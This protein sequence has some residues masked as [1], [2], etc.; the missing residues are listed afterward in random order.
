MTIL[1]VGAIEE[2]EVILKV[3]IAFD[4]TSVLV[5][6]PSTVNSFSFIAGVTAPVLFSTNSP[7]LLNTSTTNKFVF[8][9]ILLTFVKMV[10]LWP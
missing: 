6:L 9:W 10:L 5:V 7:L 8:G 4:A 1:L 2:C 3:R